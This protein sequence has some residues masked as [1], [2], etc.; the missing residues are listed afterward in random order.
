VI[1]D[2]APH[3]L[4]RE[5][6][7]AAAIVQRQFQAE[8]IRIESS[9]SLQH[10]ARHGAD[11]A[12]RATRKRTDGS[13]ETIE[14]AGD[15]LLVATGRAPNVESLGLDAAGI[16]FTQH[17][18]T[19]ND[20]LQTTNPRVYAAG[21]V[22]SR[23]KFTHAADAMAR[24]VIQNALFFGRRKASALVI[25]WATYT[26]PEIAHVGL[27]KR[28]ATAHGHKVDTI[29]VNLDEVD[30]AVLDDD[31]EGFV[32]V[33][34]EKGRLLGCT[35]VAAHAGDLIGEAS[36]ALTHRGSLG[37]LS[38]TV[39]PYPTEAEALRVAGDRYRR[40]RLTERTRHW[41]GRYFRWTR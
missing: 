31:T 13:I 27:Y 29:T 12:V 39:H 35:I 16:A 10:V 38:A 34:H 30:R 6:P 11:L 20:R 8:G 41:L 15:Q 19:V 2:G 14:V 28:E 18:V 5:D 26:D 17:G 22:C 33:H 36:Y 9:V 25:P 7:D 21:D 40:T 4:P 37:A 3:V 23:Y 1:L 24:I 32:R